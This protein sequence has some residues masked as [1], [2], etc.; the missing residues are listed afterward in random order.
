MTRPSASTETVIV[1]ML[2]N[3]TCKGRCFVEKYYYLLSKSVRFEYKSLNSCNII[4]LS[5][6]ET[7]VLPY[8]NEFSVGHFLETAIYR[9][10]STIRAEYLVIAVFIKPIQKLDMADINKII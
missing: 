6:T 10:S 7:A 1:F 8:N 5:L 4:I 3:S 2:K 9:F